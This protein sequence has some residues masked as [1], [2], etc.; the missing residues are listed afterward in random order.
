[1]G[2]TAKLPLTT[3]LAAPAEMYLLLTVQLA[4]FKGHTVHAVCGTWK[5]IVSLLHINLALLVHLFLKEPKRISIHSCQTGFSSA[6]LQ[7]RALPHDFP[8]TCLLELT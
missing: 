7:G 8:Q 3:V 4:G 1:M 2:F 5:K 6:Q